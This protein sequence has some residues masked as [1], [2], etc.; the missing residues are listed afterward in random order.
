[1]NAGGSKKASGRAAGARGAA[2]ESVPVCRGAEC[3]DDRWMDYGRADSD[4]WD[5]ITYPSTRAA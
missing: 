5:G 4:N 3:A 2:P 1:M